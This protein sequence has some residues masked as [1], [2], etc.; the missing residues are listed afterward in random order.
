M[1]WIVSA[2]VFK[3]ILDSGKLK[4]CSIKH[5][6]IIPIIIHG[7]CWVNQLL[8]IIEILVYYKYNMFAIMISEIVLGIIAPLIITVVFIV[9]YF[10]WIH[11][12]T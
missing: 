5:F 11:K 9:L 10:K 1:L 2:F 8:V 7:L 3:Y 4:K 12:N 6:N